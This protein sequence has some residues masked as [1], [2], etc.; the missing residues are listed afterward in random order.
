MY[1]TPTTTTTTTRD[2]GDRYGPMEWA[3]SYPA[4]SRAF[5]ASAVGRWMSCIACELDTCG[6]LASGESAPP[7]T[8]TADDDELKKRLLTEPGD[9][10]ALALNDGDMSD[11]GVLSV[12]L[13]YGLRGVPPTRTS[14]SWRTR[15][16]S[17]L[18]TFHCALR[19]GQRTFLPFSPR[20]VALLII[21]VMCFMFVMMHSHITN[22]VGQVRERS[23]AM[24]PLDKAHTNSHS[25]STATTS[26]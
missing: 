20:V 14:D 9:M 26:V 4:L 5:S 21:I 2:R 15:P 25:P 8:S 1:T 24:S 11:D 12:R 7:D 23:S 6:L 16:A 13:L 17:R 3:Q 22:K 18:N 19:V 10:L